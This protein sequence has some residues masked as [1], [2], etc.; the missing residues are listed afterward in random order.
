MN[1]EKFQELFTKYVEDGF[2]VIDIELTD[3]RV[4]FFNNK[5]YNFGFSNGEFW[6]G[7]NGV[8]TTVDYRV[9]NSLAI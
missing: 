2:D 7:R 4:L 3:G 8:H 1:K 5:Q 6:Y 9:I